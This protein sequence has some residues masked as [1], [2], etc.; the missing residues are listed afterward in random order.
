VSSPLQSIRGSAFPI[1]PS[2][3]AGQPEA[4]SSF[5]LALSTSGNERWSLSSA[6][7]IA[8]ATISRVNHLLSAGTRP[9]RV[10][11][12]GILNHLLVSFLVI[13]PE[14]PFVDVCMENFQFFFGSSSRSRTAS[15]L[16]L[17]KVQEEFSNHYSFRV[18]YC[19][20][21]LMS[22]YRWSQYAS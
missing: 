13:L 22:S 15:L 3:P 10:F 8:E 12:R 2:V 5:F 17:R 14:A 7:I 18:K 11:R 1:Y 19:S 16:F 4:S 9:R 6:S 20:N 21:A